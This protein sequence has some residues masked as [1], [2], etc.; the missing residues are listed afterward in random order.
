MNSEQPEAFQKVEAQELG[1]ALRAGLGTEE[2]EAFDQ[3]IPY[4]DQQVSTDYW[5]PLRVATRAAQWLNYF[6]ARSVVDVGSGVGKFCVAAALGSTCQFTGI[7]HRPRLVE[8][9]R[10]LAQLFEVS[11]RVTFVESAVIDVGWPKA[12]AYY[13]YNPFGENLASEKFQIDRDVELGLARYQREIAAAE[14]YIE[15][16]PRGTFVLTYNGFGGRVP[17]SYEEVAVDR[18][19]PYELRMWRKTRQT[20]AGRV[21]RSG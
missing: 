10:M 9:A 5:T 20:G 14:R 15:H 16:A 12:D 11:D 1:D 13:L 6:G 4:Q 17:D 7:E 3:F 18:D 8:A 21:W 2:D 19:L